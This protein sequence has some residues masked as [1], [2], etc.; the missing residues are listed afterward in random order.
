[1]KRAFAACLWLMIATL[2]NGFQTT[3]EWS[4]YTSVEGR[5]SVLFPGQPKLMT[6]Q[7]LIG[8]SGEVTQ[9]QA[10]SPD[11][12]SLYT[13]TYFDIPPGTSYSLEKGR[14]ESVVRVKGTLLNSEAI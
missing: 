8:T 10:Q 9:Y 1:M 11:S 6:Q 4:K 5:Y 12:N 13:V 7:V 2:A 3:A 14:D